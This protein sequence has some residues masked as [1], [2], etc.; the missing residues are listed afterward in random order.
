MPPFNTGAAHTRAKLG[1]NQ[2]RNCILAPFLFFLCFFSP[3]IKLSLVSGFIGGEVSRSSLEHPPKEGHIYLWLE[4][5]KALS[6]PGGMLS[7]LLLVTLQDP[8]E[9]GP[10]SMCQVRAPAVPQAD[11]ISVPWEL[12]CSLSICH[13]GGGGQQLCP[14]TALLSAPAAAGEVVCFSVPC[15]LNGTRLCFKISPIPQER[16]A[17]CWL[18]CCGFSKEPKH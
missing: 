6:S 8:G 9:F 15:P 10:S 17:S 5:V 16:L 3:D 12:T 4:A 18:S 7:P 14:C 1:N 2:S 13:R 11:G